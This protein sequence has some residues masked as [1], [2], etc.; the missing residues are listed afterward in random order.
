MFDRLKKGIAGVVQGASD[1]YTQYNNKEFMHGVTGVCAMVAIADGDIAKEEKDKMLAFMRQNDNLKV[2]DIASV[3]AS[4]ETWVKALEFSIEVGGDDVVIALKKLTPDQCRR[5]IQIG[6]AV[7]GA[8]GHVDPT[9]KTVLLGI[10]KKVGYD[11]SDFA[12]LKE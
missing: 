1:A 2:F 4:F 12:I 3:I 10:I 7:A 8:D 5:A 6:C 9:E 11:P